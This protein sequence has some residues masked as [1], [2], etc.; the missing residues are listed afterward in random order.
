MMKKYFIMSII[1][2][3]NICLASESSSSLKEI[4]KVSSEGSIARSVAPTSPRMILDAKGRQIDTK[5]QLRS[6]LSKSADNINIHTK[7][8]QNGYSPHIIKML[9]GRANNGQEEQ[10][11]R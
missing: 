4:K 2:I 5:N 7:R 3:S 11:E 6:T 8:I 9:L 1:G 10:G